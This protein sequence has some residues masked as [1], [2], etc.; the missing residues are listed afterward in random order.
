MLQ[1]ATPASVAF[2]KMAENVVKEMNKRNVN[3]AATKKVE[4]TTMRGCSTNE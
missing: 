1:G 2:V 3:L 4:I